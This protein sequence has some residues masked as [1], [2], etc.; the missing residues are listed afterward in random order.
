[1][2]SLIARGSATLHSIPFIADILARPAA[3][4]LLRYAFAGLCVT[5]LAALVYSAVVLLLSAHP[6]FANAVS[7]AFGLC[8]GYLVH[9]RWSF[10]VDGAGG[11]GLQVAR[12]LT[13][14]FVAFL[15]NSFWV[16]LLVMI[17]HLPALA[18][19]PM[20]MLVTPWISFL[21][22]RYWVFKAA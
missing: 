21:L 13:A 19:V 5:Q 2:G 1:M 8:A 16:W 3:R 10:A 9:S 7:T 20:M 6:L 22:N 12:F 4:Q 15:I 17:L 11:E 14:S 18:P